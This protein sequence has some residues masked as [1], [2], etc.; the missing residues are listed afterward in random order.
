MCVYV[1][2]FGCVCVR[3]RTCSNLFQIARLP[4]DAHSMNWFMLSLY[5]FRYRLSIEIKQA[6][7]AKRNKGIPCVTSNAR[8]W[9][10][11]WRRWCY[12]RSL[13]AYGWYQPFAMQSKQTN[14][15]SAARFSIHRRRNGRFLQ[16]GQRYDPS[17]RLLTAGRWFRFAATTWWRWWWKVRLPFKFLTFRSDSTDLR[18]E[19]VSR[20][21]Y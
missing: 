18:A 13:A 15:T 6:L 21:L 10:G 19:S 9:L 5:F 11:H 1:C 2:M 8:H 7:L 17:E 16:Q 20:Y 4:H 3:M 12:R 14:S